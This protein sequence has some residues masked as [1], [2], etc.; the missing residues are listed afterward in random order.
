MAATEAFRSLRASAFGRRFSLD[1]LLDHWRDALLACIPSELRRFLERREQSLILIPGGTTARLLLSRDG[2]QIT[3]GEL[4][5]QVPG[6]LQAML[7][8]TKGGERKTVVRLAG[9]RVLKRDVTFPAQ[10]RDNLAQVLG[11]EMDRLS[12]FQ[13]DQVYFGFRVLDDPAR[14]DKIKVELAFCLRSQVRDWLRHLRDMEMP[15]D[16]LTWEGAWPKANL[17]PIDERPQ[18]G[19]GLF[20]VNKLLS[21][22]VLLLGAVALATP[23]WQMQQTRE[24]RAAQAAE[25]K[26]R[27]EKVSQVRTALERARQGSTAV[28]QRKVEQPRMIDL[29]RELT[30]RLPDDTWVQNLDYRDGEIQI[31]GESAQ[32]TALINLL[33]QAPGITEVTFRSPVVQVSGSGRERFHISLKYKHPE[34]P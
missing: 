13:S 1:D 5:P 9:D 18:R 30:E 12:P 8:G 27:A 7:S 23:I 25:L 34:H 21:A 24:Q 11:Y 16:Q 22:L 19:S 17:L 32:A 3:L 10:V 20:S 2:E 28:L 14:R 31:R 29:L 6:S 33:D 26:A 15:V 4:D